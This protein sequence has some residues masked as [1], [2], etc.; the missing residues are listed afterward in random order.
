MPINF[1][2][3]MSLTPNMAMNKTIKLPKP[4][5]EQRDPRY[6]AET[7]RVGNSMRVYVSDGCSYLRRHPYFNKYIPLNRRWYHLQSPAERIRNATIKAERK[8]AKLNHKEMYIQ[9]EAEISIRPK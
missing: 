5:W 8:A 7:H 3:T 1:P 6:T 2:T 9:H 4:S